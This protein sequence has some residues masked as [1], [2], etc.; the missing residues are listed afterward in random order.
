MPD[1]GLGV[2]MRFSGYGVDY[3]LVLPSSGGGLIHK[4]GIAAM[5]PVR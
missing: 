2:G 1:Y 3:A 4:A 5:I